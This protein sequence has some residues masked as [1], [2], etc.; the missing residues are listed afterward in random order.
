MEKKLNVSYRIAFNNKGKLN[1]KGEGLVTVIAYS[2]SENRKKIF[3]TGVSIKPENW[4][5]QKQVVSKNHFNYIALN[6]KI[7]DTVEGI[8]N[9]ELRCLA[10]NTPFTLATLEIQ[11]NNEKKRYNNSFTEFLLSQIETNNRISHKAKENEMGAYHYFR[12]YAGNK[13]F[14][15]MTHS[16]IVN[17]DN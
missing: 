10:D 7:R 16:I 1:K 6:D 14:S 8:R 11:G 9:I 5:K 13:L 4:D 2:K 12:E 17:F 3:N 15:E